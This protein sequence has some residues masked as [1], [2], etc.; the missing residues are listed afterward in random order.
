M[1]VVGGKITA[2]VVTVETILEN[3]HRKKNIH[4]STVLTAN[5]YILVNIVNFIKFCTVFSNKI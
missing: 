3:L 5:L 4:D 1:V 2:P